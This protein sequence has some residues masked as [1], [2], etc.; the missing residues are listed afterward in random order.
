MEFFRDS[1]VRDVAEELRLNLNYDYLFPNHRRHFT[2]QVH[3]KF[4]SEVDK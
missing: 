1:S 3:K 2:H 4:A